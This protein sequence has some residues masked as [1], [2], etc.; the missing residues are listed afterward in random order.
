MENASKALIIAGAILLAILII[1]LGMAV[2]TRVK[3]VAND[4]KIND[5]KVQAY[6]SDF[7]AYEGIQ[8]GSQVRA[9]CDKIRS[10][11]LANSTDTTLLISISEGEATDVLKTAHDDDTNC[12]TED[13]NN[14]KATIKAGN[15]YEVNFGYD[16]HTGYIVDCKVKKR[17]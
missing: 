13:I 8:S 12:K 1:G 11:N 10:H 17:T 16:G 2:Y 7:E 14:F 3:D 15:Q 9:L 5:T 6:N 4:D